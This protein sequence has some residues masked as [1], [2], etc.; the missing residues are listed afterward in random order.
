MIGRNTGG[1]VRY[2]YTIVLAANN[3]KT[4]CFGLALGALEK[5][6]RKYQGFAPSRGGFV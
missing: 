1:R 3:V 4:K 6:T 5:F 2:S